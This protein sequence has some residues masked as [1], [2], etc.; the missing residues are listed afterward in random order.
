MSLA[1]VATDTKGNGTAK[2]AKGGTIVFTPTADFDGT[3]RFSYTVIDSTGLESTASVT[4]AWSRYRVR[5]EV[6]LARSSVSAVVALSIRLCR[7]NASSS[8]LRA[9]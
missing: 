9:E 6:S 4:L 8:A 1:S 7:V 5:D 3:G 2:L